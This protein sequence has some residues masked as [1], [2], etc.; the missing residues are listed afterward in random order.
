MS[1]GEAV[2]CRFVAS[3]SRSA[4]VWLTIASTVM[5]PS[6]ALSISLYE[7]VQVAIEGNPEVGEA[8]ANK[9]AIEFE[10][11]QAYGLFLP[12]VDIEG[13]Y[14]PQRFDSPGTRVLGTNDD[15]L[16]RTETNLV[17]EQLLF[18]GFN[19]QGEV[20]RQASRVDSA[21]WRIT[22]RSEAIALNV[23]RQYLETGLRT[24]IVGFSR[25]NLAYT[26]RIL[27]QLREGTTAEA[28]SIA[29]SKQAQER[30]FNAEA[31]LVEAQEELETAKIR[32]FR[33]VGKKIDVYEGVGSIV[34]AVPKTLNEAV[35]RARHKNPNIAIAKA[36][37]DTAYGAIKQARSGFY[38]KV[39][40]ELRGGYGE[41]LEAVRSY[42]VDLRAELVVR[43][44]IFRGNIDSSNVQEQL[45]R[46]DEERYGLHKAHRDVEEAVRLSWNTMIQQRRALARL[47]SQ[48]ASNNELVGLYEEQFKVGDRSLLDL[49]D[50]QRARFNS[51]IA[52]EIARNAAIF[53]EYR[54]LASTG[55]LLDTLKA[56]TS[57]DTIAT[58]RVENR[59]PVTPD[60]ETDKRYSEDYNFLGLDG[61]FNF[62][63][64]G[65]EVQTDSS[66]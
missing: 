32:F 61:M 65:Q 18:D 55:T 58:A 34:Y 22:E 9:E 48:L 37:L 51:Q 39:G 63:V 23:T 44:N 42:E 6:P 2:L 41:N 24:Q 13:R 53:A 54:L 21:A 38:P 30:V 16:F 3:A 62:N 35:D 31:R 45:R 64:L 27:G 57:T 11:K 52:V 40:V 43:W 66:H 28:L 4:A 26:R 46:A 56:V 5:W 19:R 15:D 14:G 20:E 25:A 7:S 17:I 10:L 47:R 60:G 8:V 33:L 50:T 29:D 36:D 49:L 1:S 59:V 12:K